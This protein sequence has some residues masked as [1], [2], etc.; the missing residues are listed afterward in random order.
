MV[1]FDLYPSTLLVTV[2][3]VLLFKK[4]IEVVGKKNI[5]DLTWRSYC[6]VAG[7]LGHSKLSEI[8]NKSSEARKVNLQRK[9]VSAQDEYAKWTKLNRQHDKLLAE[10]DQLNQ[11][12][13]SEKAG[14]VKYLGLLI[15]V[16]TTLPIWFFRLWFRKAVLFHLPPGYL[17]YPIERLFGLPFVVLGG[18]G[19]TVWMFS[20]NSVLTSLEFLI[21]FPF[22]TPVEKPSPVDKSKVEEVKHQN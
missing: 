6:Q 15:S 8:S 1:S 10:I 3:T 18:V 14:V 4:I 5:Q 9:A 19:L 2:L 16:L 20:V 7:K 17:P 21:K 22:E 12:L 11:G 13:A